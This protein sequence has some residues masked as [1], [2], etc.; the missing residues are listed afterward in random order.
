MEGTMDWLVRGVDWLRVFSSLL[1]QIKMLFK[2][3]GP[4]PD[5]ATLDAT[6]LGRSIITKLASL[7]NAGQLEAFYRFLAATPRGLVNVLEWVQAVVAF[8]L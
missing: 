5:V 3:E 6:G 7:A 8:W 4:F 2:R 1:A